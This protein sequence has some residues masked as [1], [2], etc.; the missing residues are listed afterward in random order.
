MVPSVSI[1]CAVLAF[2]CFGLSAIGVSTRVG[3]T[4]LGLAL[5]TVALITK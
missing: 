3:L 4:D 2:V 1:G 5:L